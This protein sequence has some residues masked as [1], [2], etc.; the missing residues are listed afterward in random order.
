MTQ[1]II[2]RITGARMARDGD[3]YRS[4]NRSFRS[5]P[6]IRRHAPGGE[7]TFDVPG[8]IYEIGNAQFV[9]LR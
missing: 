1:S 8:S 5:G 7:A 6:R 4:V 9:G 3:H 2:D